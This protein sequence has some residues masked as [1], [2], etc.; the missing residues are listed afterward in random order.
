MDELRPLTG[1]RPLLLI[2]IA[3]TIAALAALTIILAGRRDL[4]ASIL[5]ANDTAAPSTR[6]LNSPLG[7][8]F[9]LGRRGA[10][11]W[12]A[13]L[14]A[15]GLILGLTAKATESVWSSNS[16]GLLVRLGGAAGGAAYLGI[17]FLIVALVVAMAAAGQVAATR[18]EEADGSI[19]NLLARP[20]ARLPWLAGRFAVSAAVLAGAGVVTGLFTW[21]GAAAT[22]AGL[23]FATLL[24]AGVNVVPAGI[25]VLGI[26][27]LAHGLVPRFA[28]AIAYGVVAWSFLVEIVGASLGVSR[29]L[30]DLSVLHHIARAPADAVRWDSAAILIAIGI[31]AAIAGAL[32]FAR[33]DLAGA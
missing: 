23:S 24:A 8:A 5:P 21:A 11:G 4:G 12:L 33:R 28:A 14:S 9:R 15:G 25:F 32:A 20:V 31:A 3:G 26:G 6:T 29:W 27:T 16:G 1:S 17:A 10:I 18:D 2:P 22:S 19:D 7:L 30:L 13:G